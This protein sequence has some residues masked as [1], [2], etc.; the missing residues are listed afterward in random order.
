MKLWSQRSI[1]ET[2]L[3]NP[4]FCCL[5]LASSVASYSN[6]KSEGLPYPLSFMILPIILHR[7][8]RELLPRTSR[9]SM[10]SWIQEN[11]KVRIQFGDRVISLKSYTNEAIL[12]G[13]NHQWLKIDQ[14]LLLHT[15]KTTAIINSSI[16]NFDNEVKNCVKKAKIIGDWFAGTASIPTIMSLWGIRP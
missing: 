16:Q 12:F 5:I 1:E 2:S 14:D 15:T 9:T 10:T 4:A 11:T 8:T 13:F 7:E 6:L 3:L